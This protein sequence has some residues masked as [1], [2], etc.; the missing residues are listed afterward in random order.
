MTATPIPRTLAIILYGDLDIS[1]IDEQIKSI[2]ANKKEL[3]SQM[4]DVIKTTNEKT[5]AAEKMTKLNERVKASDKYSDELK[6]SVA[7]KTRQALT[8]KTAAER[9]F[10]ILMDKIDAESA[11]IARTEAIMKRTG[12]WGGMR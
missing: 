1:I 10:D 11:M 9:A 7:N 5:E 2:Q 3:E 6:E 4:G 12:R 8:D